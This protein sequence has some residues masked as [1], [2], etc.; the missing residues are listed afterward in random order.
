[1]RAADLAGLAGNAAAI[2]AVAGALARA[3]RPSLRAAAAGLGAVLALAP[4][5]AGLPLAAQLRGVVGDLSVTSLVLLCGWL[6]RE[7]RA[8]GPPAP[9]RTLELELLLAA[10]G[11]FLYPLALGLG[12]SDPYRL[13]YGSPWLLCVLLA[14]TLAGVALDRPLLAA[15]VALAV[16]GWAV[17][18]LE[19]RNLWDY[20][21]DPLCCAWALAA[22][23]R[24]AGTALRRS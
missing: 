20:L 1:V 7:A 22:L 19:S 18:A 21:L 10:G 23:A 15:S 14:V 5:G 2:A 11:L 24:R 13:G 12:R 6:W 3:A 17:E 4:L 9:R 8:A 16:L